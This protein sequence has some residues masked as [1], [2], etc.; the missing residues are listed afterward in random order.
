VT[1]KA[2]FFDAGN[3]L[4]RPYPSVGAVYARIARRHGTRVEAGWVE[5]RFA[6]EWKRRN[7]LSRLKSEREEK[8]WWRGL[9]RRVFG[10]AFQKEDAF[11]A[12]YEELYREFAMPHTWRLFPET[13]S[14]LK[15]LKKRGAAVGIVSNWDSRLFTLC[16]ALGVTPLVDFILASAVEGTVKPEREIFRRALRKAGVKAAEALHVGDS[17][18]EDYWGS[19]RVGIRPLLIAR[20]GRGV[21]GADCVRSLRELLTTAAS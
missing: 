21:P 16:D 15:T 11:E 12:Y 14:V 8:S 10:T 9:V 2:Y 17:Y 1:P 6:A 18:R 19:K 20:T 3:T 13:L 5:R 7:G 4:F